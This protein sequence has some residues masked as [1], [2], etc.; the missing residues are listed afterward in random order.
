[1][2]GM[3]WDLRPLTYDLL[4]GR[5]VIVA[6]TTSDDDYY[7]GGWF[8]TD[9]GAAVCEPARHRPVPIGRSCGE[10]GVEIVAEDAGLLIPHVAPR[11]PIELIAYHL[12]CFAAT[13]GRPS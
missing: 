12:S 11:S 5:R 7:P 10:C 2:T 8:G 4:E 9:W 13:I 3:S 1:M 6:R